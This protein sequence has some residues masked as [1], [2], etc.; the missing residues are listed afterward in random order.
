[1]LQ[2]LK[3]WTKAGAVVVLIGM[4]PAAF[5]AAPAGADREELV[6]MFFSPAMHKAMDANKDGMVTR[7]EYLNYMGAQF[8][9]MD[10]KKKGMLSMQDFTDK[11]M[12][13]STFPMSSNRIDG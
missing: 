1:M 12:M 8:D 5:A 3:S 2:R 13:Q 10:A 11:K 6:K 9:K 4:A 7:Q